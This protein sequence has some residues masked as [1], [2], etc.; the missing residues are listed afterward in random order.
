MR[1]S[2]RGDGTIARTA[3]LGLTAAAAFGLTACSSA[4]SGGA[5][6]PAPTS[7]AATAAAAAPAPS[8]AAGLG[9]GVSVTAPGSV[10]PGNDSPGAAVSG[11]INALNTK[12]FAALCPYQ[13]P[14]VQDK[15]KAAASAAPTDQLPFATNPQLGY[16]AISGTKALVGT[17]GKFCSPGQTP[18]CYSNSDPAAIFSGGKSFGDL[19]TQTLNNSSSTSYSLVPV[20]QISGH[21]YVYTSSN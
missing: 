21:W 18:E 4:A 15:C 20:E 14:N 9:T 12:N 17:T 10:Q 16:V 3:L 1:F 8:W 2:L 11:E 7:G 19:W 13:L 5:P 6:G